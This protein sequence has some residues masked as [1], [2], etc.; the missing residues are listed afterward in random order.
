ME[1]RN[2]HFDRP[3]SR[4]TDNSDHKKMRRLV[5]KY[6]FIISWSSLD[7]QQIS[8][9]ASF[10]CTLLLAKRCQTFALSG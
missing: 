1:E 2:I 6:L 8:S 9:G 10:Y 5:S 3:L 4:F 7:D